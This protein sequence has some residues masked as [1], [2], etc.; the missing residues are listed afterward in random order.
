ME[1]DTISEKFDINFI[2][3]RLIPREEFIAS[4]LPLAFTST[5]NLNV[6][7]SPWYNI[8]GKLSL[9]CPRGLCLYKTY[10]SIFLF[11]MLD[12]LDPESHDFLLCI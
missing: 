12:F 10:H 6:R 8:L 5:R 2:F 3:T 7:F 9:K 4:K 11:M 1:A